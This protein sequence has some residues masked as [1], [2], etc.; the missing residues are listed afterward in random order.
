MSKRF[1]LLVI[2]VCIG[3]SIPNLGRAVEVRA[4][5]K[6]AD[7]RKIS[8]SL[9]PA[10]SLTYGKSTKLCVSVL[11]VTEAG[12]V[13][14]TV[15]KP[16][17]IFSKERIVDATCSGAAFELKSSH[18]VSSCDQIDEFRVYATVSGSVVPKV[19]SVGRLIRPISAQSEFLEGGNHFCSDL[20][21]NG[22]PIYLTRPIFGGI[23]EWKVT[24][25]GNDT[26][27]DF[28]GLFLD[29][30]FDTNPFRQFSSNGAPK[31][32]CNP[33]PPKPHGRAIGEGGLGANSLVDNR[34]SCRSWLY[35]ECYTGRIQTLLIG[36]CTLPKRGISVQVDNDG[37]FSTARSDAPGGL[38]ATSPAITAE[39]QREKAYANSTF[40]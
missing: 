38:L 34:S 33:D 7:A 17:A 40:P 39:K 27:A 29:E 37:N 21:L 11:P 20:D 22:N 4:S 3:G 31:A 25:V 32:L 14:L 9:P 15:N 30:K 19:E 35:P 8:L 5:G 13:K 26:N 36:N 10:F 1:L 16:E 2:G 24:I 18:T 12:S 28:S 23:V 6:N